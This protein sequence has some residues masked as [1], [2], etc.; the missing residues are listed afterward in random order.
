MVLT[1][2]RAMQMYLH[3]LL[4]MFYGICMKLFISSTFKL[5]NSMDLFEIGCHLYKLNFFI[6]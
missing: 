4:R 5:Y 2:L 1:Q 3:Q 6:I